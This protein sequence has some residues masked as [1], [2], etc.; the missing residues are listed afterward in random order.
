MEAGG[1]LEGYDTDDDEDDGDARDLDDAVQDDD[2]ESYVDYDEIVSLTVFHG[3]P[4]PT[5]FA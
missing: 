1:A 5:D 2:F 3:L 4:Q